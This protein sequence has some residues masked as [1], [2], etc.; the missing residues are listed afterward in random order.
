MP[1][2]PRTKIPNSRIAEWNPTVCCRPYVL[3]AKMATRLRQCSDFQ[4]GALM[5]LVGGLGPG[6]FPPRGRRS[7]L[8]RWEHGRNEELIM[9]KLTTLTD[10]LSAAAVTT[11]P[12]LTLR[13]PGSFFELRKSRHR[14]Q[15]GNSKAHRGLNK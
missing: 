8:S 11:V 3:T 4:L 10:F 5:A 6:V 7:H 1:R 12:M 14:L 2:L 9:Q 15:S 13:R